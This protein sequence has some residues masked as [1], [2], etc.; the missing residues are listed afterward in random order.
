MQPDPARGD[1]GKNSRTG[2]HNHLANEKSPYL[3]QH[4]ENPVDWYPWGPEA[5]EKAK[6]DI[7]HARGLTRSLMDN[8]FIETPPADM[9]KKALDYAVQQVKKCS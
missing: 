8:G 4:A 7:E 3:L 6:K 9:V 2:Q 5:F 1:H